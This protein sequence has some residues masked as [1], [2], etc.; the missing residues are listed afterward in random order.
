VLPRFTPIRLVTE[1][2][3]TLNAIFCTVLLVYATLAR[4]GRTVNIAADPCYRPL[5][6]NAV[7]FG[8][9][10][11][12]AVSFGGWG[13]KK[14]FYG[15]RYAAI[16]GATTQDQIRFGPNNTDTIK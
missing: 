12:A 13:V 15:D 16:P 3:M 5:I 6:R 1:W 2:F 11:A 9:L 4:S 10:G 7:I 8:L 14:A